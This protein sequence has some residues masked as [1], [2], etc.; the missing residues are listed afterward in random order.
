MNKSNI[1]KYLVIGLVLLEAISISLTI[2][3]FTNKDALE[4]EE[5]SKIDRKKFATYVENESGSYVEYT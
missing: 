5:T 1:K 4:I 3:S 2:K